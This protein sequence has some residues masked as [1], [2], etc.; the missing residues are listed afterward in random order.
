MVTYVAFVGL[1]SFLYQSV[2]FLTE[3]LPLLYTG[4]F[5]EQTFSSAAK[6][7]PKTINR[8]TKKTFDQI[9]GNYPES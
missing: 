4:V 5:S 2:T 6:N 1:F 7:P 3:Y 8:D 9:F